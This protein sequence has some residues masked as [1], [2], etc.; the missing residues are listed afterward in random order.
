MMM[1]SMYVHRKKRSR[2]G[3]WHSRRSLAQAVDSLRLRRDQL[4]PQACAGTR[5][6]HQGRPGNLLTRIQPA[7]TL[8]LQTG[9][10]VAQQQAR[11]MRLCSW[12]KQRPK[13]SNLLAAAE[14]HW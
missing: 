13:C 10:E 8:Q 11:R 1:M 7:S 3:R 2:A 9:V 5:A 6:S 14:A 12:G 4:Q